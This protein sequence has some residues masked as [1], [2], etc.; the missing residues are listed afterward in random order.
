M[1]QLHDKLTALFAV[2]SRLPG[3]N[4]GKSDD[5]IMFEDGVHLVPAE[6][7]RGLPDFE[8]L[9]RAP[10]GEDGR[11]A[12]GDGDTR[13][14]DTIAAVLHHAAEL[15][16]LLEHPTLQVMLKV[17]QERER[18]VGA[19]GFDTDHDD[20]HKPYEMLYAAAWYM[21]SAAEVAHFSDTGKPPVIKL[22]GAKGVLYSMHWPW[23]ASWY[24]PKS[25]Q[26]DLE[27]AVA[28][29]I[30]A[31]EHQSRLAEAEE[32]K[33]LPQDEISRMT[34]AILNVAGYRGGVTGKA[35]KEAIKAANRSALRISKKV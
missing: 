19:E 12:H 20:Q 21:F 9:T 28:L 32:F 29:G 26:R 10:N 4:W 30:A 5:R 11:G 25:P 8:A 35:F 13:T 24:K 23:E 18:Q 22:L 2:I 31:M 7:G 3:R 14:F 6:A 17:L 16:D 33:K 15:R 34:L 1:G 27:R